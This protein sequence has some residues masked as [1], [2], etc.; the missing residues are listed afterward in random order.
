MLSD[1]TLKDYLCDYFLNSNN[2]SYYRFL[3]EVDRYIRKVLLRKISNR[4]LIEDTAQEVLLGLHKSLDSFDK[5]KPILPWI[6]SIIFHKT[7]DFYRKQKRNSSF[8]QIENHEIELVEISM[9]DKLALKE[10]VESLSS[11]VF[12]HQYLQ[13]KLMGVS[14]DDISLDLG[15]TKSNTKV[16][17]HRLTKKVKRSLNE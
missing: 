16:L 7:I 12:G 15:F 17:F 3:K 2:D 13:Q 11:E 10:I 4:E 8:D 6:N 9:E 1:S 5:S 14:I